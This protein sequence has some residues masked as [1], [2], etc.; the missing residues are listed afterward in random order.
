VLENEAVLENATEFSVVPRW[1]GERRHDVLVSGQ[2]RPIARMQR[3]LRDANGGRVITDML[4][5]LGPDLRYSIGMVD[6]SN[7]GRAFG[8]GEN[9]KVGPQIGRVSMASRARK[10]EASGEF[11]QYGLGLLT[12]VE[13]RGTRLVHYSGPDSP[14]FTIAKPGGSS[15]CEFTIHDTG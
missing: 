12:R 1:S 2:R 6:P 10:G 11:E 14:G 9:L 5:V 3:V 15:R 4:R 13:E 7:P 8:I